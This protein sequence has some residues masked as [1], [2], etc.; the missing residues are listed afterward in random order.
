[1]CTVVEPAY[2]SDSFACEVRDSAVGCDGGLV[3]VGGVVDVVDAELCAVARATDACMCD[4]DACDGIAA[5]NGMVGTAFAACTIPM[6]PLGSFF[7]AFSSDSYA[8]ATRAYAALMDACA[9]LW[10]EYAALWADA[11]LRRARETLSGSAIGAAERSGPSR[12]SSSVSTASVVRATKRN[13][14]Q[15]NATKRNEATNPYN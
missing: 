15:R 14:T 6:Q 1:M 12:C 13:E 3:C 10:T 8:A 4:V 7:A 2:Q 9:E 11:R 5:G